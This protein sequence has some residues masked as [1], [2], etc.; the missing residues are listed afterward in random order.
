MEANLFLSKPVIETKY[1]FSAGRISGSL[2]KSAQ[3]IILN[4]D[5]NGAFNIIRKAVPESDFRKLKDEAEGLF[6]PQCG[7][8]TC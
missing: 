2:Y 4:A 5:I 8:L 3:G 1:V 7:L 6:I